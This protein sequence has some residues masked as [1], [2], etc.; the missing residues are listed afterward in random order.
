[1]VKV[2]GVLGLAW[3]NLVLL[4]LS[5]YN[6]FY[7]LYPLGITS[8]CMLIWK[9]IPAAR[10]QN[11]AFEYIL[12]LILFIYIPGME[13]C[14]RDLLWCMLTVH[15]ILRSFHAHDGSEEEGHEGKGAEGGIGQKPS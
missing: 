10:S 12:K 3:G 13:W 15:R 8:E 9:A 4:R 14:C 1:M 5:R 7:V 11:L 2:S 6:A